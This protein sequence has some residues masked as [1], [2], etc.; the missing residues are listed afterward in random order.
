MVDCDFAFEGDRLAGV[1]GRGTEVGEMG[2]GMQVGLFGNKLTKDEDP[3]TG[4]AVSAVEV[5]VTG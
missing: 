3:G 5:E 4:K 1:A 2:G